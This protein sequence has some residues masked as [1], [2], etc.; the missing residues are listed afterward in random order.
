MLR[1]QLL[2]E[3]GWEKADVGMMYKN[4][5]NK[6]HS[7]Y[8]RKTK[9]EDY[10]KEN[11]LKL[12]NSPKMRNET[13]EEKPVKSRAERGINTMVSKDTMGKQKMCLT[14]ISTDIDNTLPLLS[15]FSDFESLNDMRSSEESLI[16]AYDSEW[17][18]PSGNVYEYRSLLSWQFACI[19]EGILYEFIFTKTNLNCDL[20]LDIAIARI[21]DELNYA[22]YDKRKVLT[23]KSLCSD[24]VFKEMK[25]ATKE[26]A[27]NNCK[28]KY[29]DGKSYKISYDFS[30]I[31]R[32]NITLLCH[33]GICDITAFDKKYLNKEGILKKCKSIGGGTVTLSPVYINPCSLKSTYNNSNHIHIYPITLNIADTMCHTSK[34]KSSLES[35][36]KVVG[37]HKIF[38]DSY[39]KENMSQFYVNYPVN[40]FE[41]ASRDSVITLLYA[42]S[43]YGYNKRIPITIT[44]AGCNLMVKKMMESLNVLTTEAFNR[45]Y[46]GLEKEKKGIDLKDNIMGKCSFNEKSDLVAFSDDVKRVHQYSSDSYRGGYNICPIVGYYDKIT[47]DFDLKNAYPTAMCLVPD[48]NWEMCIKREY[49]DYELKLSDFKENGK[50]NPLKMFICD[51]SF[52]FPDNVK[53]PSIMMSDDGVPLFLKK[54]TGLEK[55]YV[56]GPELYLA[57]RLGAKVFVKHG[58]LLN[59]DFDGEKRYTLRS[60]TK[61]FVDDRTKAKEL[62]GK[63]C[64]EEHI[65]KLIVN[66]GYGKISQD[67]S[68]KYTY[69][70][71]TNEMEDIGCSKITNPV[72]ASFIT[73]IVRCILIAA[74]NQISEL[75]YNTYSVTTDGFISDIPFD[76][77]SE[78]DLYGFREI[79]EEARL[80]LTDNKDASFWEIKHV[81]DDLLNFVTRGNVSLHDSLKNPFIYNGKEFEGVCAHNGLKSGYISDSYEDRKWLFKSVLS[82]N[83]KILNSVDRFTSL[84]EINQG[85]EFKKWSVP[86]NSSCNYDMKRKPIRESFEKRLVF[87]DGVEY[88]IV[89]FET[90]AFI[91]IE[92]YRKFRQLQKN[93]KCLRTETDWNK[94]YVKLSSDESDV[95]CKVGDVQWSI[96]RSCI[97]R[98]RMGENTIK[99]LDVLS[100]KK[101][102]EWINKHNDSGKTFTSNDWKNAGDNKRFANV[103]SEDIIKDK[104]EELINAT[105]YKDFL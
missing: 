64:L 15:H 90:E 77:L 104:L 73:S 46:R 105:D 96:L 45:I 63:D 30:E 1:N 33:S 79:I 43:L 12:N 97:M 56:C 87:I 85:I 86:N 42:A 66:S 3:A 62:F 75:G 5:Y 88:E 22:S 38:L 67:V 7:L 41:Y 55:V 91:D 57:L 34:D 19:Y 25:Y 23:F 102:N 100:G 26:E 4:D 35:L 84:K 47:F 2:R 28:M 83:D 71:Y 103:L 95:K 54:S 11:G 82:R 58:Y 18:Y 9:L 53:Y 10:L 14:P 32:Y 17:Y 44:S 81:Q 76:K 13:E 78:L 36:G 52:E 98:H 99:A 48:V 80:Y 101:R 65:L 39:I 92:E 69:N 70:D 27:I 24:K 49:N 93:S 89:N 40:Y 74:Q 29:Q 20:S 51:V 94:F 72:F 31:G 59:T 37:L 60:V 21:L 68:Q 16:I 8:I 50:Y 6:K 61:V